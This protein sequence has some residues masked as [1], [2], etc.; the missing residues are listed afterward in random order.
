MPQGAR[1]ERSRPPP[2]RRRHAF[3]DAL[4]GSTRCAWSDEG[5]SKGK[6][7]GEGK[8]EDKATL[9]AAIVAACESALAR[10]VRAGQIVVAVGQLKA[11]AKNLIS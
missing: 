7:K 8:G 3:Y 2:A 4:A 11:P 10:G 9:D 6:T 5:K 1:S